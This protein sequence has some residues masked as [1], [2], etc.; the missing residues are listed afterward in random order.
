MDVDELRDQIVKATASNHALADRL[1]KAG[2]WLD[3]PALSA[4]DRAITH[5]QTQVKAALRALL[6]RAQLTSLVAAFPRES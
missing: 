5:H 1:E 6:S 4:E 2:A 3:R